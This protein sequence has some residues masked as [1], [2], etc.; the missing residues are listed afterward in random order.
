M[1]K[2]PWPRPVQVVPL[3]LAQ[4]C[5]SHTAYTIQTLTRHRQHDQLPFLVSPT[6]LRTVYGEVV[7]GETGAAKYNWTKDPKCRTYTV[8]QGGSITALARSSLPSLLTV[9]MQYLPR[10]PCYCIQYLP[11]GSVHEVGDASTG[12]QPLYG[13]VIKCPAIH[14][15]IA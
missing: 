4:T 11:Q 12:A 2:A 3:A 6:C 1:R 13:L 14:Q 8:E 10:T 15:A 5:L 9:M 7:Y